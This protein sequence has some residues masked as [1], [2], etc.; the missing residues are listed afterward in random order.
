MM[1]VVLFRVEEMAGVSILFEVNWIGGPPFTEEVNMSPGIKTLVLSSFIAGV[2]IFLNCEIFDLGNGRSE[3]IEG[4][5]TFFV[6]EGYEHPGS[7]AEPRIRLSMRTEKIYGCCNFSIESN[8]SRYPSVVFVQ[9][10]GIHMPDVC[11]T[12]FGPAASSTFLD[13]PEGKY[14]LYFSYGNRTDRYAVLVT[15]SLIKL[16]E[17]QSEFT[18]TDYALFWRYPPNSFVYLC[19][20]TDET[21]WI[22]DDLLD[23]LMN[24]IELLEFQFPDSGKI[25]YP[26]SSHGHRYE[27]PAKF[28]LYEQEEDFEQAGEVL[29]RYT[30]D[31]ISQYQGVGVSLINW[32]QKGYYSWLF[33]NE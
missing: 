29:R 5:I 14:S 12:A 11:L 16:L 23:S 19:G 15:N 22:C 27:M 18:R 21:A 4:D 30:E 6:N 33:G 2:S 32:K 20:T 25:P 13:L 7:M 26:A 1:Q 8:V 24:E 3:P 17:E 31:V 9:L 10:L 28:F